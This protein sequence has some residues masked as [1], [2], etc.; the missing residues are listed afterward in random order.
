MKKQP[1]LPAIPKKLGRP[2]IGKK[3]L[4]PS[5][6]MARYRKKTDT[7]RVEVLLSPELVKFIDDSRNG[8]R[9]DFIASLLVALADAEG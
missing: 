9:S 7:V 8:S 4:T 5:Q 3:P 1:D 2:T 6:R